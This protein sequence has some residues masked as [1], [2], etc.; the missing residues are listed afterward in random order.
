M[1]PFTD[2][3]TYALLSGTRKIPIRETERPNC[4]WGSSEE[5][6]SSS[7]YTLFFEVTFQIQC[8]YFECSKLCMCVYLKKKN[9][10]CVACSHLTLP[11]SW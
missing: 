9:C 11:Q 4:Y 7:T 6:I 2:G 8:T 5:V 3:S 10:V 1:V